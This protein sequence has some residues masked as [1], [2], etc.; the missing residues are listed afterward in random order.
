VIYTNQ[1]TVYMTVEAKDI[2]AIRL[3]EA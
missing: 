3:L 1:H 2:Q